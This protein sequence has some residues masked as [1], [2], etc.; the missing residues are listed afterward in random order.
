[1]LRNE[2]RSAPRGLADLLLAYALVEDGILLQH[3]GRS[4]RVGHF[5]VP[6]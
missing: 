5:R 2:H 4:L 6:T 3:D 1:M